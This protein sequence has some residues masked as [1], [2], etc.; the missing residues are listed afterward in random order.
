MQKKGF[1]LIELL[2]VIAII[3][4][5]AAI[6]LPALARA[7]EAARRK[8]CQNNLK[9]W[10]NTFKLYSDEQRDYW[11][12]M[13]VTNPNIA[14]WP[15]GTGLS[16]FSA[17]DE[18]GVNPQV[19]CWYPNYNNDPAI[20]ICP[21]DPEDTVDSLKDPNGDFNI[22]RPGN[23]RKAD[24]SYIYLGW[25]LDRLNHPD[26]PP[27]DINT[28]PALSAAAALG[29]IDLPTDSPLITQQFGVMLNALLQSVIDYV[30]GASSIATN[31][32]GI[33]LQKIAD[34]N[35]TVTYGQGNA[36]SD[37]IYRF[38]EGNE[39]Y[40]ITDIDSP[41][42]A[43]FAQSSIWAMMDTYGN[44]RRVEYFN[45][46]PGGCNVLYM[47]GH[48]EWVPY[49]KPSPN[50]PPTLVDIGSNAPVLPSLGRFIGQVF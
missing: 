44:Y 32:A 13:Q 10:G 16:G 25:M 46:V 11:P 49:V 1:T 39:R 26:M 8:S 7:R 31:P 9:Q 20:L 48:V 21:S 17:M 22:W 3:G 2:V 27:V 34:G 4:I 30:T 14:G 38:K 33:A 12:F 35:F 18:V 29:L 19:S 15:G 37:V 50:T 45:H 24:A 5:L 36:G 40:L 41:E 6:L 42:T 28:L 43:S 47:D 23:A